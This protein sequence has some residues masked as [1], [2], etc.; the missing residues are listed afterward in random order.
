MG[1]S[2]RAVWPQQSLSSIIGGSL[3]RRAWMLAFTSQFESLFLLEMARRLLF[4]RLDRITSCFV[5]A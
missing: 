3:S 4:S 1:K 2:V 5:Y